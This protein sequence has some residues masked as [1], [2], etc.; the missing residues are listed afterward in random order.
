MINQ[1]HTSCRDCAFAKYTKGTQ[2]GCE[3]DRVQSY[4]DSG[5]EVL[6]A[7]DDNGK[8]FLCH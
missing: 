6:E 2:V 3:F 8:E 1:L 4:R 7:Y 5:A